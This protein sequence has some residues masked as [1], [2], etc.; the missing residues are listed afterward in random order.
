MLDITKL[1][2]APGIPG[3]G[4][5]DYPPTRE[6]CAAQWGTA[7]GAYAATIVPPSTTIG[8]AT[9]ELTEALDTAFRHVERAGDADAWQQVAGDME[10]AMRTWASRIAVG[11]TAAGWSGTPPLT[12]VGFLSLFARPYP[13]SRAAAVTRL[14]GAIDAWMRKGTAKLLSPPNTVVPWT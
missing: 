3:A 9:V 14:A 13:S 10:Q 4:D 12:P 6:A 11:M 2:N 7:L 8:P 1:T 5:A